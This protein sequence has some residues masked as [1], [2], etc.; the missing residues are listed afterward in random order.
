MKIS[1]ELLDPPIV[2]NRVLGFTHVKM[3]ESCIRAVLTV[4]ETGL[5]LEAVSLVDPLCKLVA[6]SVT[7]AA[8]ETKP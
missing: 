8:L 4:E 7:A 6:A 3:C 5:P 1:I 2:N